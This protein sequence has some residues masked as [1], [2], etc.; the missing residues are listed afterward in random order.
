PNNEVLVEMSY[1]RAPLSL[2]QHLFDLRTSGYTPVLAH[3]ERYEFYHNHFSSYDQLRELG[4][5]FQLNLLSLSN[6]YGTQCNK[7]ALQL[8]QNGF[9]THIGTDT[10]KP[11]HI[12][13]LRT[14]KIKKKYTS[15]LAE[16]IHL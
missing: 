11:R 12:E 6:Y 3:P 4:C 15:P 2:H 10:H 14:I 13:A 5:K 7:T 8:L 9:Y 16:I 1:L